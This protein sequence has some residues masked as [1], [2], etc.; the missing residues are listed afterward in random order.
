MDS[1]FF[2]DDMFIGAGDTAEFPNFDDKYVFENLSITDANNNT[3]GSNFYARDSGKTKRASVVANSR[4]NTDFLEPHNFAFSMPAT[5]DVGMKQSSV[6]DFELF[7]EFLAVDSQPSKLGSFGRPQSANQ[8]II[9]SPAP[10]NSFMASSCPSR[11]NMPMS[12]SSF[13]SS[14]GEYTAEQLSAMSEEERRKYKREKNRLASERCRR[15]KMV[16][17]EELSNRCIELEK[18]N[19]RLVAENQQLTSQLEAL[20]SAKRT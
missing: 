10:I 6:S 17:V 4:S 13:S 15:K 3:S 9:S 18:L 1:E 8:P 20:Q 7:S 11:P 2:L 5:Y 19:A 12:P 16:V 14:F